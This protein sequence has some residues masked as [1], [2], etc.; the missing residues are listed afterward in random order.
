MHTHRE[1]ELDEPKGYGA[2]MRDRAYNENLYIYRSVG[3]GIFGA[4]TVEF[5]DR[6]KKRRKESTRTRTL[7]C[8]IICYLKIMVSGL[9]SSWTRPRQQKY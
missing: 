2:R 7:L 3:E 8:I 4:L 1:E 9:M 5:G 6:L